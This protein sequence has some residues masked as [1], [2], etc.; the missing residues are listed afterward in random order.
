[1][2]V[3]SL[4]LDDTLNG[5]CRSKSSIHGSSAQL[6]SPPTSRGSLGEPALQK[7]R[8]ALED[9]NLYGSQRNRCVKGYTFL[10]IMGKGAFGSVYKAKKDKSGAVLAVKELSLD[11]VS[12]F[13][14]TTEERQKTK[15]KVMSEVEIL[16]KVGSD[17]TG[18]SRRRP[19]PRDPGP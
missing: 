1:M 16:S 12:T 6:S 10:D 13:G 5:L 9:I 17:L 11:V 7:T 2:A 4:L 18:R 19:A 15:T 8:E 3:D 14:A